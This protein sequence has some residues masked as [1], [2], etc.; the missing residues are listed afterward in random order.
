MVLAVAAAVGVYVALV[1]AA[2][3][4]RRAWRLRFGVVFH[5]FAVAV[6]VLAA[7]TVAGGGTPGPGLRR[8]VGAIALVLAAFPITTV[9]NRVLWRRAAAADGRGETPRVLAD[10]TGIVLVLAAL[11]VVLEFGYGVQ[12]PGL[13]AGSGVVALVFGLAL[14]DLLANLFA[15]IALYLQ[16][17]FATGDWLL[18]DGRDAR[19]IEVSWRS[20]RLVT[21][22]DVLVDVPNST[23]VR[24]TITNFERPSLRHA[25]RATYPLHDEVPPAR[26]V[27]VLRRAAAGVD[28]VC[29]DPAP[30]VLIKEF[31]ENAIVYDIL[32]WI[33]DHAQAPRV[34][35]DVRSH[36]WYAVHRAGFDSPFPTMA[37]RRAGANRV[38]DRARA[39]AARAL[40]DHPIFGFLGPD[41]IAAVI[42]ESPVVR[43]APGEPIVAQDSAGD[44]MFLLVDGR[45]DVRL[46]RDGQTAGVAE[47]G[48]GDCFGEMSVLTGEPRNATVVA[49]S[50]VHAVESTKSAMTA[51][52]STSPDVVGR[53]SELL[54]DRQRAN[55]RFAVAGATVDPAAAS[56]AGMLQR[57][58][59]FFQ[60]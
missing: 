29:V 34:L 17:P 22:D 37:L 21:L 41:R 13:L 48:P 15:G 3:A 59:S 24:N 36:I 53:L 10:A 7:L 6:A 47:L 25:V 51:L 58:R 9:L 56:T 33:E 32:V 60:L 23:I 45:V 2:Q 19:V 38:D 55:D 18:V 26:A 57:L 16:K 27:D 11:L 50:E 46:R 52:V 54:V 1:A 5:L 49:R 14:Q 30:K 39:A 44:S 35:S 28:G 40:G 20:T 31:G 8:H 43:F 4:A 12:V 42:D